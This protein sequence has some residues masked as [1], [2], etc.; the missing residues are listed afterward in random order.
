VLGFL[1]TWILVPMPWMHSLQ[2]LVQYLFLFLVV[3]ASS[4]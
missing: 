3:F 2:M 4:F 1:V